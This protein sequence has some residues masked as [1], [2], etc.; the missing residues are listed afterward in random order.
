MKR[1]ALLDWGIA[2]RILREKRYCQYS[3]LQR[4]HCEVDTTSTS[5][6]LARDT[7]SRQVADPRPIAQRQNDAKPMRV[8]RFRHELLP[9]PIAYYQKE[10]L[11]LVGRGEWRSAL[12]PFHKDRS[13]SL[14]IHIATGAFRCMAC[15]EKGGD[16]LAFHRL[17]YSLGF[18]AA[19]KDLGAWA[20]VPR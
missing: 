13:P 5:P 16:V 17:L 12:C 14:R 19:A 2:S 4:S 3:K 8:G 20:E 9:V 11:K 6:R 10:G 7:K 15:G 18:V 1:N